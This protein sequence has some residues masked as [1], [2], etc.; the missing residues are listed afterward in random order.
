MV[1]WPSTFAINLWLLPVSELPTNINWRVNILFWQSALG[2]STNSTWHLLSGSVTFQRCTVLIT[3]RKSVAVKRRVL[4]D[5]CRFLHHKSFHCYWIPEMLKKMWCGN[6]NAV[7]P[8]TI[9]SRWPFKTILAA[10]KVRGLKLWS[11]LIPHPM[12]WKHAA[13]LSEQT[14]QDVR[15]DLFALC[16]RGCSDFI[17]SS[18]VDFIKASSRAVVVGRV[19]SGPP[20]IFPKKRQGKKRANSLRAALTFTPCVFFFFGRASKSVQL[21]VTQKLPHNYKTHQKASYQ[22]LTPILPPCF[23]Q[24]IYLFLNKMC[25]FKHPPFFFFF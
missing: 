20:L 15:G 25:F 5:L 23:Y 2:D 6:L 12:V 4:R 3:R 7:R 16:L 1:Y 14:R 18:V 22:R 11:T 21:S 19:W 13:S 9:F 10:N 24:F 8:V 17:D